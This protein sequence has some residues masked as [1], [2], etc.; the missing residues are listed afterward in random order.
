ML[1]PSLRQKQQ[2]QQQQKQYYFTEN[3]K[4][5]KP[6][7]ISGSK[8]VFFFFNLQ[9]FNCSSVLSFALLLGKP[10]EN[11]SLISTFIKT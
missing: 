9:F 6:P 7:N 10:L 1:E 11:S 5:S 4:M 8:G 2:Q 3:S